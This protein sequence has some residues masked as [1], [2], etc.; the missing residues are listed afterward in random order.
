MRAFAASFLAPSC[1]FSASFFA[2]PFWLV[3]MVEIADMISCSDNRAYQMSIV[4][5]FA[6]PAIASR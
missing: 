6:N 4:P 5:I 1:R 2:L 3:T